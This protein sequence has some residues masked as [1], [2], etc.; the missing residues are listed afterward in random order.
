MDPSDVWLLVV[1]VILLYLSSFFS[2]AETSLTTAN[3][4]RL[5]SLAEGGDRNAVLVLEMLEDQSR[6]L[7]TILIGNN[8]VNLSASSLVTLLTHKIGGSL[9]VGLGTGI[10]TLVVLIFGEISPKTIATLRAEKMALQY[11]P[12]IHWLM[13]LMTPLIFIVNALSNLCLRV[14]RVNPDEKGEVITEE[15]LRTIVE[16]SH[17]EGVLEIEE[18]EMINNVFDLGDSQARD[19]M[20]PRV[21]VLFVRI[22]TP[23]EELLKLFRK[24]HY[25]RMPV[26]EDTPDNVIGI[27]NMKDL[28]LYDQRTPF[29]IQ[30][31][32]REAFYT[33]EYKNTNELFHEMRK[34]STTMAIVLDEYGTTVGVITIEDILEEIVGDIR[35][36]YD[37]SELEAVQKL[38]ENVYLVEGSYKIEDLN[39]DIG[40]DLTSEEYDS[41]GGYFIGLLDHFPDT[42]EQITSPDGYHFI[43]AKV[44]GNRIE[45]IRLILPSK[46]KEEG[47]GE[48]ASSEERSGSRVARLI[49]EQR[50]SAKEK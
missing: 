17:E 15:E 4:H 35:D 27:L 28:V 16:V 40:T 32:M 19:V 22:D 18:K 21:D 47:E 24:E 23:Y 30:H 49:A 2:S 34:D 14:L 26:Y 7:T 48:E 37:A 44:K 29:S 46:K 43:A 11:A 41:I 25:T 39:D 38:D 5:R 45:K 13:I 10:L 33:H 31:F 36:E 3:K 6:M 20:V 1:L 9:A 42:G 8:I 12:I 50:E